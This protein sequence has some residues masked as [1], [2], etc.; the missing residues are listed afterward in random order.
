MTINQSNNKKTKHY[1]SLFVILI[2]SSQLFAIPPEHKLK[3]SG[4][5]SDFVVDNNLLYAA[6]DIGTIDI[7]SLKTHKKIRTINFPEITDFAGDLIAPKLFAIDKLSG[8]EFILAAV[9][10]QGGFSD[11]YIVKNNKPQKII[12][13]T[14]D[15]MLAKR[16]VIVDKNTILIGLMSNE[17]VLFEISTHREIYRKQ[18]STASFSD[19]EIDDTRA[20]ITTS[21]ESGKL[22][23]INIRTGKIIKTFEGRNKDNVYAVGYSKL[24]F[25]A[26]GQDREVGVYKFSGESY[27]LKSD[28]LVY[29]ANISKSA[30]YGAYSANENNDIFVFDIETKAKL[31]ELHGQES[32]QTKIYFLDDNTL[33]SSSEDPNILIWNLKKS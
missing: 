31:A 20:L 5:V 9:Q 7:F 8:Q 16:A 32:T 3:A 11:I 15:K 14:K 29:S 24:T 13:A 33:I 22:W 21:E 10:G 18:L 12:D 6:T 26:A 1:I 4:G 23:F 28:F 17:L 19:F 2:L 25:I 27:A 30:K